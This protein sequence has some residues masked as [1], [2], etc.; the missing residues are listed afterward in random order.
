MTGRAY[1]GEVLNQVWLK[2]SLAEILDKQVNAQKEKT[3]GLHAS[4]R[5]PTKSVLLIW[6]R[7]ISGIA[8]INM[9]NS[10]QLL[11]ALQVFYKKTCCTT[12]KI[13]SL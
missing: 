4:S 5:K 7:V 2:P 10:C 1:L 6:L 13:L 9:L 12:A 11:V 3:S 8:S